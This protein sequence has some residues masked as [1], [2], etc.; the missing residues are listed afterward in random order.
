MRCF[1]R[2]NKTTEE[3]FYDSDRG[4]YSGTY[5]RLIGVSADIKL[6]AFIGFSAFFRY[7]RGKCS[8]GECFPASWNAHRGIYCVLGKDKGFDN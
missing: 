3:K 2:L 5:S 6:G 4:H 8:A 1:G 7:S